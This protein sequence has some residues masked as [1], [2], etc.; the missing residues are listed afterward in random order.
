MVTIIQKELADYFTSI[1]FWILLAL[2]IG[3]SAA[4]LKFDF[5][6]IRAYAGTE[7]I[8]LRLFTTQPGGILSLFTFL[9]FIAL[10]LIPIIGI[11]LGFDAVSDERSSGTLSRLLSQPIFRDSVIN[12]KFLAGLFIMSIVVITTTLITTGYGLRLIGVPPSLEEVSRLIIFVFY[13]IIYGA[14]WMGLAILF[15][16]V[17][18]RISTSLLSSIAVWLF[19]FLFILLIAPAIANALAPTADGT[20]EMLIRNA[21]L[22]QT[23]SRFSP[24]YLFL[25]AATVLLNPPS[26]GTLLL[27]GIS[28][29]GNPLSLQ[30]SLLLIWPHFTTL[31]SITLILFAIS[32]V[33]FMRQ[34]IRST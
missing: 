3:I 15:S 22:T 10:F 28:T 11:A 17:V 30:Q 16:V 25:E 32:Y 1:R 2:A 24:N 12:A 13:A 26:Y 7:L 27:V 6:G 33:V 4:Q 31:V 19:F 9:P 5:D 8:F 23:I 18:R 34:E 29:P 14:F 21:Q 20:Q